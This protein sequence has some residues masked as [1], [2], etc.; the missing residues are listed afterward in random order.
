MVQIFCYRLGSFYANLGSPFF[1]LFSFA[2]I[3]SLIILYC[4]FLQC[5]LYTHIGDIVNQTTHLHHHLVSLNHLVYLEMF[6]V[7]SI[8]MR[9]S[10]FFSLSFF[11]ETIWFNFQLGLRVFRSTLHCNIVSAW[12]CLNLFFFSSEISFDQCQ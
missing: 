7:E 5:I 9:F 6:I 2:D 12:W 8:F 11:L 4:S 1:F 3:L 10:L